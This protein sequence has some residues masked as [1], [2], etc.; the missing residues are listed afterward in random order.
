MC[1]L[2]AVSIL[3]FTQSTYRVNEA[4]RSVQLVLVLSQPA[5]TNITV[6]V[7]SIDKSAKGT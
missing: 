3:R 1:V 5:T 6:I 7:S 2:I 4:D